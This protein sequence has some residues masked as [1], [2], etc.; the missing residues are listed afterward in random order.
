[1]LLS[2]VYRCVDLISDSLGVLPLVTYSID[3]AGFKSEHTKHPA[4]DLLNLEPNE[5]MT[6][7]VFLKTMMSSVL[8]NGNGYAYIERDSRLN[9]VQL[10]Y[11]P[12]NLVGIEWIK[13]NSGI[14]RKRYRVSSFNELLEPKSMLHFLNFSYDGIVGVS[15]LTHARQTLGIATDSEE[16]A[17]GFF[18]S[19]ASMSGVLTVEGAK[20][21]QGQK[22]QIY[23]EWSRRTDP[24]T[25]NPN[26]IVVLE[27]GQKY[28]PISISPK[29]SQLLESRQLNVLD[30]C[31]FFSVPP[32]KAYDTSKNSYNSLEASQLHY[33]TDTVLS[34]IT[35]FELE[36]NR[37][38]FLPSE[39]NRVRAEF[40]TST[41]LRTDKAAQ[42]TY[43][44]EMFNIAGATPNEVR[45]ENNL[46]RLDGGDEAFVQVNVQTLKQAVM[47][48]TLVQE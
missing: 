5:N 3:S 16:H 48:K 44:R 11:I 25:G 6:R 20:L 7:F 32:E 24:V 36:I 21:R 41:L 4:Y 42:A 9:P 23:T 30:I 10:V 13:D 2:A 40:N 1:M 18:K 22:E 15:T 34:I 39:R 31:R 37:K 12:S 45:K 28:Q 43:W 8:L 33:L 17:A 29:D 47:D 26:G 35:K 38:L 19:G 14:F 27:G 46:P